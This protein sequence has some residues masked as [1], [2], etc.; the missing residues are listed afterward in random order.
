MSSLSDNYFKVK[1]QIAEAC[2]KAGRKPDSV[3][4]IAVSKTHPV[5][6]IEELYQLG[7]RDF[8]ENRIKE[9]CDKK[10]TLN[11]WDIQWH[12]I[13]QLQTNKV[14]FLEPAFIVH[15]LDRL[16]LVEKLAQRFSNVRCL[17]EVNCSGEASKSGVAVEQFWD[18]V[19]KI[20][21]KPQ[22]QVLGLMTLAEHTNDEKRIRAAFATLRGLSEKLAGQKIF[23]TYAN[24]LSMGMSHDFPWAIAEGATHVRIG[25]AIFGERLLPNTKAAE[26]PT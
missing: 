21:Q 5:S 13:G 9:L 8:G 3:V 25:T 18:L 19:D 10:A 22:I 26:N 14:K 7:H 16:S 4:L 15:S 20:A 6:A 24:W 11:H 2:R 1:E 17:I 23:P 12:L